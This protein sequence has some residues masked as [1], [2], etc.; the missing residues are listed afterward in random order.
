MQDREEET[1]MSDR[2]TASDEPFACPYC[3]LPS[4]SEGRLQTHINHRHD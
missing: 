1:T 2:Q 4:W 3:G